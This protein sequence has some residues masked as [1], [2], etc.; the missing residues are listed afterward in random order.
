MQIGHFTYFNGMYNLQLLKIIPFYLKKT[1]FF[2]GRELSLW[3]LTVI[4][5]L[6]SFFSCFIDIIFLCSSTYTQKVLML[7]FLVY[8]PAFWYIFEKYTVPFLLMNGF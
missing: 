3:W 7:V 5:G 4:I 8:E 6:A 1:L 2:N